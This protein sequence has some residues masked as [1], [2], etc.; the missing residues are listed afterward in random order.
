MEVASVIPGRN[1]E[2]CRDRWT[3]RINPKVPRGKWTAE[4]DRR[5]ISA[6]N[7]LGVGKW[8]EV[9]ERVGT[10]RTDNTVSSWKF[11]PVN[12]NFECSVGTDTIS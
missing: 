7:K 10:G 3:E 11:H 8:K 2:Q 9:S 6:V 5:L 12:T 4:E 1:N